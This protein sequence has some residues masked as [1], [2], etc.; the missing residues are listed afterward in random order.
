MRDGSRRTF[1]ELAPSALLAE[2]LAGAEC[3]HARAHLARL[4]PARGRAV[5]PGPLCVTLER[6]RHGP[7]VAAGGETGGTLAAREYLVCEKTDGVRYALAF[8]RGPD[9]AGAVALFGREAA[10]PPL[11]APPGPA[12]TDD[13]VFDGTVLDGELCVS[14]EG[15]AVFA[16]FDAVAVRGR[17]VHA[18]PD[19]RARLAL[20]ASVVADALA[21]APD[22]CFDV[23]VKTFFVLGRGGL[24]AARAAMDRSARALGGADGYVLTPSDAP[25][26]VG[27]DEASFKIK[28]VH[29]LDLVLG[30]DGSLSAA[31]ARGGLVVVARADPSSTTDPSLVGSVVECAPPSVVVDDDGSAPEWRV[32]RPRP[33]KKRP[34]DVATFRRTLATIRDAVGL[35]EAWAWASV[36]TGAPA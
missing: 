10:A 30:A 13:A 21:P 15:R 31:S 11:R 27:R 5:F 35:D 4:S 28:D 33:D 25:V 29:T 36:G 32:V 34:N 20:A 23:G 6:E 8:L 24:A 19:L 22:G 1:V 17:P 18:V 7:L 12:V 2:R 16:V 3:D 14:A 9:G 26:V